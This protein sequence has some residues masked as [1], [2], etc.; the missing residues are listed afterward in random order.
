MCVLIA[1]LLQLG[2]ALSCKIPNRKKA[3][4]TLYRNTTIA[5]LHS[6]ACNNVTEINKIQPGH[7]TAKLSIR[8]VHYFTLHKATI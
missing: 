5:S 7:F 3:L 8:G 1:V 2:F 6:I 4:T